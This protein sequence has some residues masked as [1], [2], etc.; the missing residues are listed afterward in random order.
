MHFNIV[1]TIACLWIQADTPKKKR[2]FE[3][4]RKKVLT[5]RRC[6]YCGERPCI[7]DETNDRVDEEALRRHEE[8]Y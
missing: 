7:C 1:K 4:L 2:Q 8:N 5:G 6:L 3:V